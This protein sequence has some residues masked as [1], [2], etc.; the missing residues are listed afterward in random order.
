MAKKDRTKEI[1][2]IPKRGNVHQTI[3]MVKVLSSDQFN[4]KTWTSGKQEKLATEMSKAGLTK[5]GK[6]LTHQSVRT[7]LANL[8]KYLGFTYIDKNSIPPRIFVTD[9][10]FELLNKHKL[11]P[12]NY[13]KLK[14]Y[15]TSGD[16][17]ETSE[18]FCKQLLK[19]IITNPSIIS[20]CINILVFPFKFT[21]RLL[22]ELEYL[23]IQELAYI[24]F[25]VKT[26]DEFNLTIKRIQNFRSVNGNKRIA[27]INAFIQTNE[28]KLTLIKAPSAGYYMTLCTS[29]GLIERSSRKIKNLSK[30]LPVILLKDK[31][32]TQEFLKEYQDVNIFNF[33]DDWF[34]W[35]EYYTI[36]SRKYTPQTITFSLNQNNEV[37]LIVEKNGIQIKS[38]TLCYQKNLHIHCFPFEE[39]QISIYDLTNGRIKFHQRVSFDLDDNY[40]ILDL[41]KESKVKNTLLQKK[42]ID[43]IK[44]FFSS[45]DGFDQN[46][47]KKL[48]VLE[49]ILK[50]DL[51]D[52]YR[53]GGRLE[54][55]FYS[56]LEKVKE[57][58]IIDEVYWYGS[59]DEY[60]IAKPAPGGKEGNPDIVFEKNNYQFILE[61]TTMQG[62][63]AQWASGEASSVPDHIAKFNK[64][65]NKVTIGI[66]CAPSIHKQVRQNLLLNAKKEKVGMI[67]L[68]CYDL[69]QLLESFNKKK[70]SDSLVNLAN[71]QLK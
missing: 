53:R 27:E 3:Y 2:H 47:S 68:S 17:I 4:G 57:K 39:Y 31:K 16:L 35:K 43:I 36:P 48:S 20:D 9:V 42:F 69:V 18:V 23:D 60:G 38:G 62:N 33:N 67:F 5:S 70:I 55:I 6:A 58:G 29:S 45:K 71:T 21:L 19:L 15:K 28:G 12:N 46:Y 41:K 10:G 49:K 30:K 14:D 8:P 26:M 40:F 34:L 56:L 51:K 37:L 11:I 22:I 65:S 1:W 7:L 13:K 59:L 44:E 50:K 54:F 52:K 64:S 63:R 66:F 32:K 25:K 24:V 61:L